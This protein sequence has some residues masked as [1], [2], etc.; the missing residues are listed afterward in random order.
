MSK[1]HAERVPGSQASGAH[2][3]GKA[4][5]ACAKTDL[6][7]WVNLTTGTAGTELGICAILWVEKLRKHS[8]LLF[9][10]AI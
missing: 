9:C 10:F 7:S 2:G 3:P 4:W 6:L 8:F 1:V 5:P